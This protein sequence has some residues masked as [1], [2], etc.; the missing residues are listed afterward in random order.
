[1][2][3]R[4]RTVSAQERALWKQATAQDTPFHSDTDAFVEEEQFADDVRQAPQSVTQTDNPQSISAPRSKREGHIYAPLVFGDTHSMDARAARRFARG[5]LQVARVLDLH[6]ATRSMAYSALLSQIKSMIVSH[7]R[8]LMV[9]TGKGRANDGVLKQALPQWINDVS[10]RPH[11]VAAIP[12]PYHMG[13]A[14]A[15]L[16]LLRRTR[17]L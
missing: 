8:V 6:G 16:I 2:V 11:I 15:A 12:A 4:T 9:I 17:A 1:M 10:I 14:G 3:I 13:G 5:E 7:E